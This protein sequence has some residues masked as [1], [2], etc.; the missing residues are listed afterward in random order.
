MMHD[1]RTHSDSGDYTWTEPH[2]EQPAYTSHLVA[3]LQDAM[4]GNGPQ[5]EPMARAYRISGERI[6]CEHVRHAPGHA[7]YDVRPFP[8]RL[9]DDIDA[10]R[11][12]VA[13]LRAVVTDMEDALTELGVRIR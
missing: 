7:I 6:T 1:T 11:V 3:E 5:P 8:Q 9:M 13:T 12:E 4:D 2:T 10:L